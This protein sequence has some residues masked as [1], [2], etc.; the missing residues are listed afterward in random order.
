[1]AHQTLECLALSAALALAIPVTAQL[2]ANYPHDLGI[3]NDPH[4]LYVEKFDDGLAAIFSRYDDNKNTVGMSL[5]ADVPPGS[6]G[7]YALKMTSLGGSNSGGHLFKRFTPGWDS[8]VYL[9]YYV[10]YPAASQGYI[11]HE[12]VWIGGYQPA[13]PWPNPQAGTCGLGDSRIAIAY[14]PVGQTNMNTYLYWGEMHP[15][16]NGDCW[17]N[18]MIRGSLTPKPVPFDEWLCVEMMIRLNNPAS[19]SNGAL[20]IWHNG[21]EVGYWGPGFPGGTWTWDKFNVN[22]NDPPFPGFRWRSDPGLNLN[23]I[24]IEYYDDQSPPGAAHSIEYD[25][26]V[27]ATQPIG[28][29]F[30]PSA[31]GEAEDSVSDIQVFPNP[32]GDR[33][34]VSAPAGAAPAALTLFNGLG[35]QVLDGRSA[36]LDLSGLAAGLYWLEIRLGR[37]VAWRQVVKTD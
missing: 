22:P 7:P 29:I 4:V 23:Y 16:P 11:H 5:V 8:T 15:D 9:R 34:R 13:T 12:S 27:L 32:A 28:P 10:K 2:A 24:W 37:R 20:R 17:G 33:L 3:E 26:L 18:V 14:E 30:D 25:H 35:Q 21:E 1:M 36:E 31:A 19:A 6:P